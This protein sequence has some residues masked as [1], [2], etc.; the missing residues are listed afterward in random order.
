MQLSKQAFEDL[1]KA[2]DQAYEQ[3]FNEKFSDSEVQEIGEVL[4]TILAEGLKTKV[5]NSKYNNYSE[6]STLGQ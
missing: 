1:R 3:D 6:P 4:L 2:L 5:F